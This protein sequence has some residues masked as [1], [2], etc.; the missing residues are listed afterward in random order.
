MDGGTI[1]VTL[2]PE[3]MQLPSERTTVRLAPARHGAP[4]RTI[5][6]LGFGVF[7]D[8]QTLANFWAECF[9]NVTSGLA[10]C[11][12][13]AARC[14]AAR[15]TWCPAAPHGRRAWRRRRPPRSSSWCRC[16]C[17][18]ALVWMHAHRGELCAGT[19][20]QLLSLGSS[21]CRHRCLLCGFHRVAGH[22]ECDRCTSHLQE[23][24]RS[25][26][27]ACFKSRRR[28]CGVGAGRCG[29]HAAPGPAC[30][31]CL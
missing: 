24:S 13:G 25:D 10:G 23:Y 19:M 2:T 20:L 9:D 18:L 5:G 30:R 16:C 31:Q 3:R 4:H 15:W 26:Q 21:W 22:R 17:S 8:R 1:D 14:W 27:P 6:F 29:R 12:S 11:A 7:D 28:C